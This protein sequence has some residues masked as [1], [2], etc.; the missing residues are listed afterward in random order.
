MVATLQGNITEFYLAR[1]YEKYHL[2][3]T[4]HDRALE[5]CISLISVF[6]WVDQH[7]LF[8]YFTL[9]NLAPIHKHKKST[10]FRL[11]E[12]INNNQLHDYWLNN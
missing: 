4:K 10:G 6:L 7:I 9:I 2:L 8:A 12:L 3:E 1:E 5:P 11:I